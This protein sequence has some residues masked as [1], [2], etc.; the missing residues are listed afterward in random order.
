V[1]KGG[2][3]VEEERVMGIE[4]SEEDEKRIVSWALEKSEQADTSSEMTNGIG[5]VQ[6]INMSHLQRG[7][8]CREHRPSKY[9][10]TIVRLP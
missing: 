7:Q 6:G 1:G 9:D 4:R 10:P 2:G 3:R 8:S 5:S